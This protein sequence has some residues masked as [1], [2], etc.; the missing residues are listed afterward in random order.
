MLRKVYM[1]PDWVYPMGLIYRT[2]I[3]ND[4]EIQAAYKEIFNKD[5]ELPKSLEE[6]VELCKFMT[7][8]T[9]LYGSSMQGGRGDSNV[10]EYSNYLYSVG[11]S[12]YDDN[13]NATINDAL[14]VKAAELY[15]ENIVNTAPDGAVAFNFDDALRVFLQG[16]S[17]AMASH[18]IILPMLDDPEYSKVGGKWGLVPMPGKNSFAGGWGWAVADNSQYK[19]EAWEFIEWVESDEVVKARALEGDFVCQTALYSDPD[20]I[21]KYDFYP[22]LL[23]IIEQARAVPEFLYSAE[24]I[25]VVGRELSL[26]CSGGK[27]AQEGMDLAAK[28]LDELA[29]KANLK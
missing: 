24:M 14:G 6:Y 15:K 25:E 22:L 26:V 21:A 8:N 23:E 3:M 2:D 10:M 4:P 28:E 12:Y 13:W 16:E 27:T 20:V 7:E 5:L 11:G 29:V 19:D 1:I 17:F 9:D 18:T